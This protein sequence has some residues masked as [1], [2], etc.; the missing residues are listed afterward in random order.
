MHFCRVHLVGYV[1]MLGLSD[2]FRQDSVGKD[3]PCHRL[4]VCILPF[5]ALVATTHWLLELLYTQLQHQ[6]KLSGKV[7]AIASSSDIVMIHASLFQ[8]VVLFLSTSLVTKSQ[9]ITFYQ[10]RSKEHTV[11]IFT[12][13]CCKCKTLIYPSLFSWILSL[14]VENMRG[15]RPRSART[16]SFPVSDCCNVR[17]G[18]FTV[19]KVRSCH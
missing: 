3:Q 1:R 12:L 2:F 13:W 9:G 14:V 6:K 18:K 17:Y 10:K 11:R 7:C 19:I 16:N 15:H 8:E 4:R 5:A